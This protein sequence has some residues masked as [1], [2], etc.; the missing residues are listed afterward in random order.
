VAITKSG[1]TA[2]RIIL[3][4]SNKEQAVEPHSLFSYYFATKP[5]FL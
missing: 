3:H 2:C 5:T 4:Q 1:V